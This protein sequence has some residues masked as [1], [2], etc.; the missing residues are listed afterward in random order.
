MPSH[1][2]GNRLRVRLYDDCLDVFVGGTYSSPAAR[3]AVSERQ[4]RLGRRLTVC[5]PFPAAQT[6]GAAQSG[7]L[8]DR[9]RAMP[10]GYD[11]LRGRL[12][13]KK[14]CRLMA[15][16]SAV[17]R[18]NSP[19]SSRPTLTPVDARRLAVLR[20]RFAPDPACVPHVVVQLLRSPPLSALSLPPRSQTPQEHGHY[21][22]TVRLN[23]FLDDLRLPAIEVLWRQ[24]AAQSDKEG[25]LAP[26]PSPRRDR[27]TRP[28]PRRAPFRRGVAACRKDLRQ[29]R[30]RGRAD[31]LQGAGDCARCRRR[32]VR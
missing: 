20:A 29:L 8:I 14:G 27:R 16:M 7:L 21:A 25:W 23:L 12:A 22:D 11:S 30:L 32:L 31:G 2:I 15:D 3:A 26:P 13:G 24:F 6:C 9:F 28:A 1:L 17:A 19:V 4:A 10:I 5:D 18:P